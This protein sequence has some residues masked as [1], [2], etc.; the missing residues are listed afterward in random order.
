MA[1][2]S[3]TLPSRI[4]ASAV[5]SSNNAKTMTQV[6]QLIQQIRELKLTIKLSE[7]DLKSHQAQ[8]DE[9]RANG[10]L[11]PYE[12]EDGSYYVLNCR[13]LPVTRSSWK[14]SKAVKELQE[15]EQ[16]SGIATKQEVTYL[17]F[18]PP[19]PEAQ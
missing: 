17:R 12:G 18:D 15:R 9:Y 5:N 19:K 8:L 3:A 4:C 14:Y 11:D 1:M 16:L 2:Q 13:L 7:E 10:L 6:E